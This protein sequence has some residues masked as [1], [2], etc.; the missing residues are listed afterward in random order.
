MTAFG[1]ALTL[2]TPDGNG[3]GNGREVRN[4]YRRS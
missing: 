3:D 1:I 4:A 2:A